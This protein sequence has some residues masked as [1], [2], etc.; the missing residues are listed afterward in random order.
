MRVIQ[1]IAQTNVL[2]SKCSNRVRIDKRMVIFRL[3][4]FPETASFTK[5]N[6][7][8]KITEVCFVCIILSLK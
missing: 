8:I 2:N 1:R 5:W 7:K 3:V 4:S 6:S